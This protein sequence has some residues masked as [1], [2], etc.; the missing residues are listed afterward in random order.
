MIIPRTHACV[1]ENEAFD[2]DIVD[3]EEA[4]LMENFLSV[5]YAQRF[6]YPLDFFNFYPKKKVHSSKL[7]FFVGLS[8]NFFPLS[9]KGYRGGSNSTVFKWQEN[10]IQKCS[11]LLKIPKGIKK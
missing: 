1:K 6:K 7:A 4:H 9:L 11:F 8:L 3:Y 2:L 5:E 10:N